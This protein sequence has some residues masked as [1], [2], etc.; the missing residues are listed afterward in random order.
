MPGRVRFYGCILLRPMSTPRTSDCM[1]TN[2]TRIIRSPILALVV[3]SFFI[4]SWPSL[5]SE[6]GA[7]LIESGPGMRAPRLETLQRELEDI[8]KRLKLTRAQREPIEQIM[9]SKAL[10]LQMARGN[11]NLSVAR[12]LVRNRRS[13]SGLAG[14]SRRF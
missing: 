5:P 1:E 8:L 10:Q 6:A 13:G 9:A 4:T 12:A 7:G 2:L 14:R 11:P 3:T